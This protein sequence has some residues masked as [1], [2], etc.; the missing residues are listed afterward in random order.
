MERS[1]AGIFYHRRRA[2]TMIVNSPFNAGD[3]YC[4]INIF[5]LEFG[6]PYRENEL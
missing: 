4:R 5:T 6:P 2:S 1:K 3:E